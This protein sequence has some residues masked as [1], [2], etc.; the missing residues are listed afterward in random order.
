MRRR[1][2][3]EVTDMSGTKVSLQRAELQI[4]GFGVGW[5]KEE[6]NNSQLPNICISGLLTGKRGD[7]YLRWNPQTDH[8]LFQLQRLCHKS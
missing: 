1:H 3:A 6:K 4:L 5:K 7:S 2:A 8:F